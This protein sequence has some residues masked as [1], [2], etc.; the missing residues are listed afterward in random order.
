MQHQP[1]LCQKGRGRE[2]HIPFH[3]MN[4]KQLYSKREHPDWHG[5]VHLCSMFSGYR[6]KTTPHHLS[7]T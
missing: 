4:I 1:G 6:D 5:A 7:E 3:N 2:S